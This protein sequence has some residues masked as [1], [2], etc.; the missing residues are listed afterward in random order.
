MIDEE[1]LKSLAEKIEQVRRLVEEIRAEGA[2]MPA[3]ERNSARILASVAMLEFNVNDVFG[4]R[5]P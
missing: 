4:S 3:V 5:L 2:G 1:R